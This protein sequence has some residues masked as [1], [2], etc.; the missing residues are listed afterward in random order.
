[1]MSNSSND[2]PTLVI[3]CKRPLLGQGKQ[4]LAATIGQ[5]AALAIAEHMLACVIEDALSWTGNLVLT[6]S[7]PKDIEWANQLIA[8]DCDVICQPQGNLGQRINAIDSLLREQG[9]TQLIYIGTDAPILTSLDYQGILLQ[10]RD[11]HAAFSRAQDGGVTIMASR[12][13]WPDIS[14]LAWSTD[15]LGKELFALCTHHK[16]T[17]GFIRDTYDIDIVTDLDKL[18]SNLAEDTRPARRNLL[19]QILRS[20]LAA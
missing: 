3:F 2:K 13:P 8:K 14:E 11:N 12:L 16:W 18:E 6:V 20:R 4:R 17:L 10:L 9:H 15:S 7:N 19:A 1:M 5:E